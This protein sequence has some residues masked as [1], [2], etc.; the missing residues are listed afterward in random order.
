MDFLKYPNQLH[1][2]KFLWRI[3]QV[4]QGFDSESERF[5]IPTKAKGSGGLYVMHF[6]CWGWGEHVY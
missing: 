5:P 4:E 6:S 2:E 1:F 3:L